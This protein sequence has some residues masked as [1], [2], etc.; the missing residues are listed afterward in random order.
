MPSILTW[1]KDTA[2]ICLK[3]KR[4]PSEIVKTRIWT[5]C[6]KSRFE[7]KE[8]A[9]QH[10]LYRP[11]SPIRNI[12]DRTE[13]NLEPSLTSGDLGR[14]PVKC[15]YCRVNIHPHESPFVARTPCTWSKCTRCRETW[16]KSK[17][18]AKQLLW[19]CWERVNFSQILHKKVC[20]CQS[21][22]PPSPVTKH[23]SSQ[24]SWAIRYE[25]LYC[26]KKWGTFTT[27]KDGPKTPPS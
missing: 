11:L 6:W 23:F 10:F 22:T 15:V 20:F 7:M 21:T 16:K 4:S 9:G 13:G 2:F 12:L 1:A 17:S 24:W 18:K 27:Q 5:C 19:L 25:L 8:A 3:Q 26:S 14:N